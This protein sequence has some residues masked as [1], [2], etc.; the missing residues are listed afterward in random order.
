MTTA[1]EEV[2]ARQ[3]PAAPPRP[4]YVAAESRSQSRPLKAETRSHCDA[5]LLSSLSSS[6]RGEHSALLLPY[7]AASEFESEFVDLNL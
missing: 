5:L 3:L 6:I 1:A 7:V 4:T 2:S